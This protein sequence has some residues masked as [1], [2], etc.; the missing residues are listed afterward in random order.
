MERISAFLLTALLLVVPVF[1]QPYRCEWQV[2]AI[3]GGEMSGGNFRSSVTAGQT[4]IG[5]LTGTNLLALIGF[6]QTDVQVGI[7]EDEEPVVPGGLKTGLARPIPNPSRFPLRLSYSLSQR[8]DVR[9]EVF[10]LSGRLVSKP[11][12]GM[13]NGGRYSVLWN[14]RDTRGRKVPYGVYFLRFRAG[15]HQ[16]KRKLI[17][18]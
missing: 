10:D 3:G 4:A 15:E 12:D 16:E 1:A 8:T 17:L 5:R 6:W 7:A 11:V 13:Q 14:G 18:Q 9:L 2:V